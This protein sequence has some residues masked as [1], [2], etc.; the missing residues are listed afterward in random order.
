MKDGPSPLV[1]PSLEGTERARH[2]GWAILLWLAVELLSGC[3]FPSLSRANFPESRKEAGVAFLR[4]VDR[5]VLPERVYLTL[6]YRR[7]PGTYFPWVRKYL[8]SF[9]R[10][11]YGAKPATDWNV[12]ER[13]GFGNSP[14]TVRCMIFFIMYFGYL[15]GT[16]PPPLYELARPGALYD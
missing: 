8:A 7:S 6:F 4:P 1:M 5:I 15:R 10:T 9:P 12:I 3:L 13:C 16:P 11:L 2:F 14:A